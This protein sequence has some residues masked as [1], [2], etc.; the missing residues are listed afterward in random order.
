MIKGS[1]KYRELVEKIEGIYTVETLSERLKLDRNKAVYVIHK[2]RKLGYVKTYYGS[3][4]KR[5]YSISLRNSNLKSISYVD[6]INKIS[7]IKLAYS[8][9]Y[10]I[11]GRVPSYE[12]TL[13]Y[14]LQKRDIRY[15]V[16]SLALFKKISNWS[17]LYN[18]AKKKD[19]VV[20][21]TALYDIAKKVVKKVRKMPK[22]FVNQAIKK[23]TKK[24]IYIIK[25]LSSKDFKDIE[26]KWNIY[27]PLNL[28]DLEDYKMRVKR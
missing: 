10:Y 2:L 4:K 11:H 23:R 8:D 21:I 18:L 3:G 20:E 19:L 9:D 22:K 15:L 1:S 25:P 16:A 12:E 17:F 5:S 6:V 28:S 7:P 13:I 24:A 27:I 14:A 26:K